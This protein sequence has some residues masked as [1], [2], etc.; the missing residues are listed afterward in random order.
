MTG[1]DEPSSTIKDPRF[2]AT[3]RHCRTSF[4]NYTMVDLYEHLQTHNISTHFEDVEVLVSTPQM[5]EEGDKE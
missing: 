5:K 2:Q 3:C 1:I 4:G